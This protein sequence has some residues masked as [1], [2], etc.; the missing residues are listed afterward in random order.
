MIRNDSTGKVLTSRHRLLRNIFRQAFGLMFR[1]RLDDEGWVF[2]LGHASDW[3]VTNLFV[4]QSIAVVW[5]DEAR[6]VLQVRRVAPF[7]LHVAGASGTRFLIE[8]PPACA[9]DVSIGDKLSWQ[10]ADKEKAI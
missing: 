4:F 7:R 8:L 9:Q 10:P 3:P 6:C 5:L 1:S 2:L